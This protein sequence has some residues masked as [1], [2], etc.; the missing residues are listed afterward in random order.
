MK[1]YIVSIIL[2]ILLGMVP[3]LLFAQQNQTVP[4]TDTEVEKLKMRVT[5][6]EGKLQ[7]VENVEKMELA[8]KLAEAEAR[9]INT[10]FDKLKLELKDSNQQWLT[11][12]ILII[13]AILSVV[14]Y[15]LWSRLTKKMDDLI[16]DRIECTA[17]GN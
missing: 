16:E 10:E 2:V 14:G 17:I 4:K 11:T 9:L 6:L 7:I 8:A 15:A 3:P 5:D 12:W 13:L 1:K